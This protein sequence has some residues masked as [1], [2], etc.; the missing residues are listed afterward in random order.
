MPTGSVFEGGIGLCVFFLLSCLCEFKCL[1]LCRCVLCLLLCVCVYVFIFVC[2]CVFVCVALKNTSLCVR[3]YCVGVRL[4]FSLVCAY[5]C[6]SVCVC[7]DRK[8]TR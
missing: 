6:V 3:V 7:Q 4:C 1:L 5:V 2:R 8:S